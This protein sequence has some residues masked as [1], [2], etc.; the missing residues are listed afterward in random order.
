M[1]NCVITNDPANVTI[2]NEMFNWMLKLSYWEMFKLHK[3]QY[4]LIGTKSL[5]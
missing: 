3:Y 5:S 1:Y 2:I 4:H